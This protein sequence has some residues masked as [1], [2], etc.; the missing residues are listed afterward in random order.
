MAKP[1]KQP[2]WAKP[3]AG[4]LEVLSI[5]KAHPGGLPF[6]STLLT[7]VQRSMMQ[8]LRTRGL[9]EFNSER[10]AWTVTEAGKSV[11]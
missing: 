8:R 5:V 10:K 4:M 6:I 2:N 11:R 1:H 7:P 3:S 9:V